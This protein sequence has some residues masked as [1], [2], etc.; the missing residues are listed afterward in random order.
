MMCTEYQKRVLKIIILEIGELLS[1][2]TKIKECGE[3]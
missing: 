2:L 1:I 3:N